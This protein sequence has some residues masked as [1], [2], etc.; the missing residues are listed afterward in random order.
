MKEVDA[1]DIIPSI[2]ITI[3]CPVKVYCKLVAQCI[4]GIFDMC[5]VM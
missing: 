3:L 5:D 4:V 1:V 2:D